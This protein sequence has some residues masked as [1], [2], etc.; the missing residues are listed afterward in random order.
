MDYGVSNTHGQCSSEEVRKI[1]ALAFT[2][3]IE[4][5]DTAAAYGESESRIASNSP[6]GC[7]FKIVTKSAPFLN[8][9]SESSKVEHLR[10][11]FAHSLEKLGQDRLYGFLVH[12][13]RDLLS[14]DGRALFAAMQDLKIQG[15]VEKIGVSVY[16]AAQIEEILAR[17][18]VDLVQ[19]PV[20]VF[21]QRLVSG[22]QLRALRQ[23]GIEIHA[24]S[25]FLQGLALIDP[26]SVP[27][28]LDLV[29]PQLRKFRASI[30]EAGMTPLCAA[31][32]FISGIKEISLALVGVTSARELS[33]IVNA[34]P[35]SIEQTLDF[36]R[37]AMSEEYIVNP[38][39][40]EQSP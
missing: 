4:I 14:S 35:S 38:A 32:S 37:F 30:A 28:R 18:E 36:S 2:Q 21:D 22:G 3:G 23:C 29:R 6:T 5:L 39:M 40:W 13:P 17:F 9:D 19:V 1:L 24:R 27:Q 8:S 11:S 20:S 12:H 25:I 10:S 26:E 15:L 7:H 33:E 16:S 31:L 34:W